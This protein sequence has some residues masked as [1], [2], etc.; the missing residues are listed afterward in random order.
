MKD[1]KF[2]ILLKQ[3]VAFGF[4]GMTI[5]A[6]SLII[7]WGCIYVGIHYQIANAIGFIITVA[8]AYVLNQKFTFK[9]HT[10]TKWSF[11]VLLKTYISYSLTGLFMAAALLWTW[12][13]VFHINENVAPLLNLIFTVPLNFF[14]N[15][16]W[17]YKGKNNGKG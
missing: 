6:L 12:T 7:Y 8:L 4:V 9:D 3:L 2:S 17:G 14:L 13:Q 5:T 11:K 10:E 16:F 1:N 15:K